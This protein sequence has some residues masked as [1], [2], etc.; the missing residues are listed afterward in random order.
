M[1]GGG[2]EWL[3]SLSTR[4]IRPGLESITCILDALGSPQKAYRTIHVAGSDGKGSVC[5][6]L[7]SILISAGYRVGMFTSPHIISV[8]ESIRINGSD[9]SDEALEKSLLVIKETSERTCGCTNFEALA[10]CAFLAFKE[11]CVDIAIIEVGMGGRLDATNVLEPD[12]TVINNIGME[13]TQYLGNDLGSIAAEKAGIMKPG[14]PCVTINTGDALKV[15]ETKAVELGCPLTCVDP[16]DIDVLNCA[17][18]HTL[19]RYDCK[20]YRLGLPGSYQGRNAVLAIEALLCLKDSAKIKQFIT[21][22]LDEAFWPCR[23]QKLDDLPIILDATH[24]VK[25]AEFLSMDIGR[26]YGKVILVTA[27]L[28]DKDMDGVARNLSKIATKV[29]ISSPDSP[30]AASAEALASHYRKY[31]DDVAIYGTVPEAVE[32]ALDQRGTVLITGSFR[33]AEDC[34]RWLRKKR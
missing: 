20:T 13:H 10:A 1:N 23:M 17:P 30:R 18:D 3:E 16:D 32:A 26:I 9:I 7:E 4:G 25:G 14:I 21:I 33:T 11:A 6:M 22:G 28:N 15:I 12:V 27:M 5:C 2:K 34:L 29:L 8:N 19:I 31:H 24:T